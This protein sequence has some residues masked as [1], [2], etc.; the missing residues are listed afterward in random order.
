VTGVVEEVTWNSIYNVYLGLISSVPLVYREGVIIPFPGITLRRGA[1]GDDVRV[2]QQY[3][4]Y[5]S[6]VYTQITKTNVNGIYDNLTE[7]SV[8]AFQELFGVDVGREGVVGSVTWD[9]ITNVYEDIYMGNMASEGQFP[10]YTI[11]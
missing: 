9:A 6:E 7:N 10:G 1:T 11:S 4:N 5:I 2:L 3:L 8:R